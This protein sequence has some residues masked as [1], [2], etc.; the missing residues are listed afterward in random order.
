MFA[1]LRSVG[2]AGNKLARNLAAPADTVSEV[3]TGLRQQLALDK[4]EK[5]ARVRGKRVAVDQVRGR[6]LSPPANAISSATQFRRQGRPGASP[7]NPRRTN[8]LRI[9]SP[10]GISRAK[11]TR[12]RRRGG[13]KLKGLSLPLVRFKMS[14]RRRRATRSQADPLRLL[15]AWIIA[16]PG[17]TG[18]N[19]PFHLRRYLPALE[20]MG[21]AEYRPGLAGD[22]GWFPVPV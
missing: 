15:L 13:A 12:D 21:W 22:S 3:N 6:R 5:P 14:Y 16:F 11:R 4:P 9:P 19:V 10:V 20:Q 8:P 2:A 7:C 1:W 17:Q 18:P